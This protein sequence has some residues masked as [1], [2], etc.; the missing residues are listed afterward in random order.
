MFLGAAGCVT[1]SKF[2]LTLGNKKVLVD[3]GLFQGSKALRLRNW[4]T[5]PIHPSEID[6]VLLTH[7]HI[8]HTGYIPL[9]IK[10]GYKGSVY[11]TP[12]TRDLCDIL[13][14]D[15]A[16]LQE[17]EAEMHNRYQ[18]SQHTP[19][20][21]LYTLDDA[22]KALKHFKVI[23]FNQ[24][25]TLF[26]GAQFNF[27][28]AGHII[29]AAF[30][31]ILYDN[32]SIL[33]SGDMGR[34]HDPI[35]REPVMVEGADYVILESTYGDRPHT[36]G[37]PQ[38]QLAEIINKTIKRGG[39]VIIPAFAVGRSQSM[40]YYLHQLK[41]AHKIP[42]VPIYLDSPMAINATKL[43]CD[44]AESHKLGK[45][46]CHLFCSVANYINTIED[47]MALDNVK[48]PVIIIASSGMATGGRVLNH[49][50]KFMPNPNNT[51][52]FTGYQAKGTRGDRI[53]SGEKEVRIY[54]E[55]I[56]V[57]AEVCVLQNISAHAD[58]PEMLE[59]LSHFT[60]KPQKVFLVH[61]EPES[62]QNFKQKIEE[63]FHWHCEIPD[64]LQKVTLS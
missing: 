46:Q 14:R 21:P 39:S 54:G 56:P 49:L 20:L 11:C 5:F 12:G 34:F 47:S 24:T 45:D 52:L 28:R 9:L 42:E 44:H 59:W 64:Y 3:C 55:M 53:V 17:E 61:G 48:H 4:N 27:L 15:S 57:N 51:I 58:Y 18:S 26:D 38:V 37:D 40:L 35:M 31:K 8:D 43:L 63:K 23:D 2:L 10:H 29:G 19:A 33:F 7:A 32:K 60:Q 36:S 1:G 16:K 62:A 6:A 13:L 50:K 22:E 30:I 25:S 41:T